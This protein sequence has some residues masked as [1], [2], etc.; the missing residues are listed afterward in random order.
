MNCVD[1]NRA[2][3]Y[4]LSVCYRELRQ[5]GGFQGIIEGVTFSA[6]KCGSGKSSH[7]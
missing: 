1:S 2:K 4:A 6:I 7:P 5:L 3:M